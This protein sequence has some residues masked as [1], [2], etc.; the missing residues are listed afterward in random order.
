M[1]I[2]ESSY[3]FRAEED[4]SDKQLGFYKSQNPANIYP[5]RAIDLKTVAGNKLITRMCESRGICNN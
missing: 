2:T 3:C 4:K 1:K 5:S